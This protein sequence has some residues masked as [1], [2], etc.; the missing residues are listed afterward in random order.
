MKKVLKLI[1]RVVHFQKG[2]NVEFVILLKDFFKV[3]GFLLR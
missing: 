2:N 1:V 3:Q